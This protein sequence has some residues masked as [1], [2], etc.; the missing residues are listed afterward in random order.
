MFEIHSFKM[1]P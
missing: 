1:A